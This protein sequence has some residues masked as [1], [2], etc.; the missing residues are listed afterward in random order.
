M[1][2]AKSAFAPGR[3]EHYELSPKTKALDALSTED[4]M[5][6]TKCGEDIIEYKS[7]LE[8]GMT[9]FSEYKYYSPFLDTAEKFRTLP[10]MQTGFRQIAAIEGFQTCGRA[11]VTLRQCSP[12]SPNGTS[13]P[14]MR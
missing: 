9:S 2:V 10:L 7:V 13:T 6:L 3:L 11:M 4:K 1:N 8:S 5:T 14:S 12:D